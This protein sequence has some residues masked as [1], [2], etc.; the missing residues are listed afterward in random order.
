MQ[1]PPSALTDPEAVA[2]NARRDL[3]PAQ[4]AALRRFLPGAAG[5]WFIL[6]FATAIFG[7]V[8]YNWRLV[9]R[10]FR[11]KDPLPSTEHLF[12][13]TVTIP[14]FHLLAALIIG[15]WALVFFS[16]IVLLIDHARDSNELKPGHV[17]AADGTIAWDR[18]A[19]VALLPGRRHPLQ[20]WDYAVIDDCPPGPYRL[21]YLRRG[22]W[23]LSIQSL[24][25]ADARAGQAALI[26]ALANANGLL[27][28]ALDTNRAGRLSEQQARGLAHAEKSRQRWQLAISIG[29]IAVAPAFWYYGALKPALLCGA[30]G[31]F[32]YVQSLLQP[33]RSA[34]DKD[35]AD[36]RVLTVEG[37]ARKAHGHTHSLL[38][39]IAGGDGTADYYYYDIAG[40]RFSV[41]ETAYH[42]LVDDVPYR[43]YYLPRSKT[44]IN[45]EPLE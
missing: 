22:G 39:S 27:P 15:C 3:T 6:A 13:H 29:F 17:V 25:S 14:G 1:P 21:W 41:S 30:A 16:R 7:V 38:G 9:S 37:G 35:L 23:L 10:V 45:I 32:L 44:I 19:Y 26:D 33:T 11:A 5:H 43:F 31:L 20:P 42:A 36:G 4:R 28:A 12:G 8:F 2:T 24:G 18:H 34:L 40:Q